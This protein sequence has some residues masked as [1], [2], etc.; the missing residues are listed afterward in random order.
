MLLRRLLRPGYLPAAA[1]GCAAAAAAS[2][3][4][5]ASA[6][7]AAPDAPTQKNK[8][9]I[10]I[11]G[12]GGTIDKDYPRAHSGYAFEICAPAAERVLAQMPF[13]GLVWRVES[14][15]AKD[16][17]EITDADRDLL[18]AALRRA[19]ETRVV[20]THGT[21]TLIQTAQYVLA[22][23]AAK[24]KAIAFVGSMK[25]ERFNDSDAHF[26]LGAAVGATSLLGAGV[27][28]VVMG[29]N[30]IDCQRAERHLDTGIFVDRGGRP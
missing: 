30:V 16:S 13:L 4:L 6:A 28:V 21:D 14:V 8:S 1:A 24:G 2:S 12:M 26:N 15:C 19:E 7:A 29:G 27:V 18:V 20:V 11:L 9:R 5:S 10:A 17:T 23:G 25:P 22:S 3:F